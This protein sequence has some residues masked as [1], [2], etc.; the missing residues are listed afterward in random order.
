MHGGQERISETFEGLEEN[1]PCV[2]FFDEIDSLIPSRKNNLSYHYASEVNELLVQLDRAS[3]RGILVIGATNLV[4]SLD[5]AAIRPGRF[6][7]HIF[8]GPPDLEAR[9][10]AF[11][12]KIEQYPHEKINY[13]SLAE[14]SECFSFADIELVVTSAIRKAHSKNTKLSQGLIFE[15]LI[16]TTP[17]IQV[18]Q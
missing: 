18:L 16:K 4:E 9:T 15:Q 13:L 12:I 5:K 3:E 17:S 2:A 7:R 14:D 6:D 11:K 10:E 8:V 1:S